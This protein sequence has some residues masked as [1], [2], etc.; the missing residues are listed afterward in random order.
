MSNIFKKI[1]PSVWLLLLHIYI[2]NAQDFSVDSILSIRDSARVDIEQAEL[3]LKMA[4]Q[5][6]DTD[7]TQAIVYAEGALD[8]AEELY[9][10]ELIAKSKLDIGTYYLNIGAYNEALVQ[11]EEALEIFET[12]EDLDSRIKTIWQ[13]GRIYWY[14]DENE[15]A[16]DYFL[17]YSKYAEVNADT[18]LLIPGLISQAAVYGNMDKLDSA[19]ILLK[20]ANQL[21]KAHGDLKN[22]MLSLFNIGDVY[23]FSGESKKA[24]EIYSQIENRFDRE[25]ME[26][27]LIIYT[28]NS[29]TYAYI[30]LN[31]VKNAEIYN[32]KAF[33]ILRKDMMFHELKRYYLLKFQTDTLGHNYKSAVNSYLKYQNLTDSLAT[34]DFKEK[35]ANFEYLYDIERKER[36]ID[37]LRLDNQLKDVEINT[38][39]FA[40][41]GSVAF[42]ILLILLFV[43]MIRSNKKTKAKSYELKI[44]K[45]DLASANKEILSQSLELSDKN[46]KL[47]KI[48]EELKQTQDHLIQSEKMASL[49]VLASGV[50][51]EI[52]NPLNFI[53]GGVYGLN[54]YLEENL[55]EHLDKIKIYSD[56]IDEGVDKAADIVKSLS[57]YNYKS[58]TEVKESKIDHIID[59]CLNI[60]RNNIEDQIE[61]EKD[62]T[63]ADYLIKCNEGKMHQAILNILSNS[64]QA[65]KAKGK[66]KIKIFVKDESLI[67]KISDNGSGI[68]KTD[69]PKIFDPFFTTKEPGEGTGLGLSITYNIIKEFN[70]VIEIESELHKGTMIT[71]TLPIL[72]K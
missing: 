27:K 49:G 9:E 60:L 10:K 71:I 30:N 33:G 32:K 41:Y 57:H 21:A 38:R 72:E 62:Y 12:L 8:I 64:V 25:K 2:V 43:Q 13:I 6:Y 65:I 58:K 34:S 28:Y 67:V 31:D 42:I 5:T 4:N 53:K 15:L 59:N 18:N 35:L 68:S 23:L 17:E 46:E 39:N 7:I 22:E 20:K 50:A 16:L 63:T 24:L 47:E 48:L 36:Q 45:E 54:E 56:S 19:L 52:N 11:L 55:P 70:G 40:L 26:K 69:L 1:L 29:M 14:S 61:I 3:L 51:H 66:I 37:K 44:Q